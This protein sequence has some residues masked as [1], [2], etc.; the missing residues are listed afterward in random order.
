MAMIT[1][2]PLST[3]TYDTLRYQMILDFEGENPLVYADAQGLA[4]IGI[5]FEVSANAPA[6]LE[7]MG[8]TSTTLGPTLFRSLVQAITSATQGVRF[9]TDS[10]AQEAINQAVNGVLGTSYNTATGNNFGYGNDTG[11]S[12]LSADAQIQATFNSIIQGYGTTVDAWLLGT[13]AAPGTT[14]PS[15]MPDSPERAALVSLAYNGLIGFAANPTTGQYL[16]NPDGSY[17][18]LSPTLQHDLVT[19]DR[20]E[21]WYEIR[22]NS[23]QNSLN[24]SVPADVQ[25]VANRR[26]EESQVFGLFSNSNAPGTAPAPS[27]TEAVQAYQML[28]AHR[29]DILAYDGLYGA[30]LGQVPPN[31]TVNYSLLGSLGINPVPTLNQALAPAETVLVQALQQQYGSI[32]AHLNPTTATDIYLNP[33]RSSPFQPVSPAYAATLDAAFSPDNSL[34]IASTGGPTGLL[35]PDIGNDLLIAGMGNDVLIAG[36]GADTLYAGSGHDTLIGGQGN[37]TLYAGTGSDTFG[38]VAPFGTTPTTETIIDTGGLGGPGGTGTVEAGNTPLTGGTPVASNY[39]GQSS[40]LMGL[41]VFARRRQNRLAQVF[42]LGLGLLWTAPVVADGLCTHPRNPTEATICAHPGLRA[43]NTTLNTVYRQA[44]TEVTTQALQKQERVWLAQRNALA[45]TDVAGLKALYRAQIQNLRCVPWRRLANTP[46]VLPKVVPNYPDIWGYTS[47]AGETLWGWALLPKGDV[48]LKLFNLKEKRIDYQRL[49][50]HR[51][52]THEDRCRIRFNVGGRPTFHATLADGRII[53]MVGGEDWT[54]RTHCYIGPATSVQVYSMD[55]KSAAKYPPIE[56][57]FLYVLDK[58]QR[59]ENG[60]IC[61]S[62]PSEHFDLRVRALP[63][64][65]FMPLPDGSFLVMS[66]GGPEVG[67][68]SFVLRFN[69][70]FQTK[71]RILKGKLFIV[72]TAKLNSWLSHADFGNDELMQRGLLRWLMATKPGR[73]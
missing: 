10:A 24:A 25:G 38:Y 28:A 23:N 73:K 48:G 26:Y 3:G 44:I 12:G 40:W 57:T 2:N 19:G 6:I 39:L 1:V 17:K 34:L 36:A 45:P 54:P 63:L 70:H 29:D 67:Y 7:G 51:P 64:L 35:T 72:D 53:T 9:P 47:P 52:L 61:E 33:G 22:Y 21:A 31:A 43:L 30:A 50:F 59:V 15:P 27:W 14:P 69:S 37:D 58:P 16:L 13:P 49:F 60:N 55:P 5:G 20:A 62:N 68:P 18:L 66:S 41:P 8:Y 42:A 11:N 71:S 46:P 65:Q 32:L 56:K 4:T